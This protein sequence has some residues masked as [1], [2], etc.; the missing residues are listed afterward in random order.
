MTIPKPVNNELSKPCSA[1]AKVALARPG[2]A[3][4]K[5]LAD[6][7]NCLGRRDTVAETRLRDLR[8]SV[9]RVAELLADEPAHIPLELPALSAR[10]CCDRSGG[11][12]PER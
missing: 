5:T 2:D 4:Q 3:S 10:L 11:P 8:S 9:R 1:K 7:L 12:R 6:V